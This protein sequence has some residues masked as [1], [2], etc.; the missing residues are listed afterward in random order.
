M[1]GLSKRE[2]LKFI[3]EKVE[4]IQLSAYEISKGTTLT[5]AGVSR[6]LKGIAKNPHEK[7][8]NIILE[9]LESKSKLNDVRTDDTSLNQS[10]KESDLIKYAECLEKENILIKEVLRLQAILRENNIP[11]DNFFDID[12]K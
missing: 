2:K 9:Y 5:E 1:Y 4:E 3:L 6:I 10:K 8:L 12:R 7:S 11:F